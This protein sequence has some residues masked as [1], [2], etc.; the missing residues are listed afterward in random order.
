MQRAVYVISKAVANQTELHNLQGTQHQFAK[1]QTASLQ[2]GPSSGE[3]N[4]VRCATGRRRPG[5]SGVT[6]CPVYMIAPL[7]L[8]SRARMSE[9]KIS[10]L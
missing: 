6:T 8:P 5:H 4:R 9:R 3:T 2:L 10:P 1:W 7:P